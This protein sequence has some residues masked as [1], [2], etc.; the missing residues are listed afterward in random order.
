LSKNGCSA[1]SWPAINIWFE[2]RTPNKTERTLLDSIGAYKAGVT[3]S[4]SNDTSPPLTRV[5]LEALLQLE[6]VTRVSRVGCSS[7]N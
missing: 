4:T 3:Y 7:I 5:Q 6:G 1:H 2:D